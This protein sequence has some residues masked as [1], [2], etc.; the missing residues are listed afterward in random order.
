[1]T[2]DLVVERHGPVS[3]ISI[4]RP[5]KRNALTRAMYH[6]LIEAI[7]QAERDPH[8]NAI[9]LGGSS[10]NF[11]VGTDIQDL[12]ADASDEPNLAIY[13]FIKTLVLCETPIVAAVEGVAAGVGTTLLFH[14]DLV[15]AAPGTTF[16]MPFVEFGLVPDAASTLLVPR[17][18]GMLKATQLLLLGNRFGPEDAVELGIANE[19]VPTDSLFS[20]A[21]RQAELLAAKPVP[22]LRAARRL[23]RSDRDEILARLDAEM[24]A[25]RTLM[26][27]E[28]GRTAFKAFLKR[29]VAA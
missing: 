15:Y 16:R 18:I 26:Q 23:I 7:E 9:V 5:A 27:S 12:F 1:M 22:A 25:F 8:V 4:N 28:E 3:K 6:G 21:L 2:S 29:K 10:G 14:C 20:H 13:N 24:A 11:T 19:V 17:R